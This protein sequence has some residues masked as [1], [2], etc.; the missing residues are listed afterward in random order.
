MEVPILIY[1]SGNFVKRVH[2]G[3][4]V[5]VM[6]WQTLDDIVF[7]PFHELNMRGFFFFKFIEKGRKE[8]KQK[9]N[10]KIWI[11]FNLQI[12]YN[13]CPLWISRRLKSWKFAIIDEKKKKKGL[14]D[15]FNDKSS[16]D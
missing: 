4:E 16:W 6:E 3:N 14:Q 12:N 1:V 10:L 11:E 13:H 7:L 15:E 8:I 5:F 2:N 9:T